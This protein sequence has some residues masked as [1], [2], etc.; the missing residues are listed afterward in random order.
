MSLPIFPTGSDPGPSFVELLRRAGAL[1]APNEGA[2]GAPGSLGRVA[3]ASRLTAR[4]ATEAA[5]AANGLP[6]I[7]HGTTIVSLRFADGVVMAGDRRATEG[8]SIAHRGIEKVFPADRH[9]AIAIAGA[10]GPAIEMVRLFQTQIEHYEKVEGTVLSLEGKANQLAQMV[11]ANLPLAMEGLVVVPL[12]AGYDLKDKLGRIFSFDV[13]GGRYEELE[14]MA[15]GS[16]GRDARTTV[17]LGY[18]P[19]LPLNEAVELAVRALYQ[20]AD[21]DSATGGPDPVRGIYPIVAVV[22]ET[23]YR[24]LTDE[25]VAERFVALLVTIEAQRR[26][27][28]S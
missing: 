1:G 24:R 20:A 6:G 28:D 17:K 23:G 18:R 19:G 21:E 3:A 15:I 27:E 8:S 9:S 7:P 14:Y 13:A 4:A 12:F 5:G 10:A 26:G 16:G 11:R 25:E 22:D 2:I